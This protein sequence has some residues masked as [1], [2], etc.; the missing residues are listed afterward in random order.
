MVISY[1]LKYLN[2]SLQNGVSIVKKEITKIISIWFISIYL[3]IPFIIAYL[4]KYCEINYPGINR[5]IWKRGRRYSIC[6]YI[7]RVNVFLP[8]H[9]FETF[10]HI[11]CR[12]SV[13]SSN[14]RSVFPH[15]IACALW[16]CLPFSSPRYDV[17]IPKEIC[18]TLSLYI[19]GSSRRGFQSAD[20][21]AST[22]RAIKLHIPA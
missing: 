9:S 19:A 17:L 2:I 12:F 20:V 21:A 11:S 5:K 15:R 1:R 6:I 4:V 10:L 13:S 14:I 18:Y 3:Y 22:G 16:L 7:R 8:G